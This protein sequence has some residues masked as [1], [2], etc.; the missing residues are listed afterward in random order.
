M[1][2]EPCQE[3]DKAE[4]QAALSLADEEPV[5]DHPEPPAGPPKDPVA[6]ACLKDTKPSS[7]PVV[8]PVNLQ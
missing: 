1:A 5:S 2:P 7:T 3:A 8:F 4:R 6:P